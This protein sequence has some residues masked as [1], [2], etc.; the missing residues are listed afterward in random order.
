MAVHDEVLEAAQRLCAER[1][2]PVFTPDEIVQSLPH[3]NPRTVRTHVTSRCAVNAPRH[4]QSRLAYFRKVAR[5]RYE[6]LGPHRTRRS[7]AA[8]RLPRKTQPAVPQ[9]D[10]IHAVV[11][12]DA[13]TYVVDCLEVAVV[14]QGRTLDEALSNLQE[15]VALHLD[16]EDL[17][18]LGLSNVRRIHVSYEIP[19][20]NDAA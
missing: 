14:T 3:L 8:G 2:N 10:T 18:T 19:A 17:T 6:L 9:R 20:A 13:G 5:G 12:K 1:D 15:A 16:G 4:H 7:R 11:I